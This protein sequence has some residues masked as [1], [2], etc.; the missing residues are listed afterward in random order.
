[1]HLPFD[2]P[3]APALFYRRDHSLE[4]ALEPGDEALQLRDLRRQ[5]FHHPR[6]QR[7]G[8]LILEYLA[9]LLS[10]FFGRSDVR[11]SGDD[12]LHPALFC[13]VA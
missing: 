12:R 9:E 6:F 13:R 10:Q 11:M 8:I 3:I 4:V 7:V 5:A 1:M 2:L